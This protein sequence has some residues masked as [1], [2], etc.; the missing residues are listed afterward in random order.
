MLLQFMHKTKV[1]A[2]GFGIAVAIIGSLAAYMMYQASAELT[3]V[4]EVIVINADLNKITIALMGNLLPQLESKVISMTEAKSSL[5]S[6][7]N[8]A[9]RLHQYAV[10]INVPDKYKSAHP[11]LV[12]GL[13]YFTSAMRS[14][15]TTFQYTE[16]ALQA[17]E[18]LQ[19]VNSTKIIGAIFGFGSLPEL[20]M[21]NVQSNVEAAK[22]AYNDA[23]RYYGQA[24]EELS[25]FYS[26]SKLPVPSKQPSIAEYSPGS[27]GATQEQLQEC[28]ELGIPAAK[29]SDQEILAKKRLNAE[30]DDANSSEANP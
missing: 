2:V 13:E 27:L 5:A 30:Q 1:V 26:L 23:L 20:E 17:S 14:G 10:K 21:P 11:H 24:E 19:T 25:T 3:Y 9:D 12:Q 28:S 22:V 7:V 29:C 15:M 8:D 18:Q 4:N 16:D 6:L